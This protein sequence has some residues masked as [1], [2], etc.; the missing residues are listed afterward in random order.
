MRCNGAN[1][2]LFPKLA[3]DRA[4]HFA[5]RNYSEICIL[6]QVAAPEHHTRRSRACD[7]D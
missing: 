5:E 7:R 6:R 3:T 1:T 4:N 2:R